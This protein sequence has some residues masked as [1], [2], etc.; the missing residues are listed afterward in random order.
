VPRRLLALL[1]LLGAAAVAAVAAAP[2]AGAHAALVGADPPA[3]ARLAAV[4]DRVTLTFSEDVA[5]SPGYLQV[6]DA[7][8][9]RVDSGPAAPVDG[10]RSRLS[11]PLR[12][13]LPPGSFLVSYAIVS[14]DSHPVS[15][16]YAFV[17]G[18]GPLLPASGGGSAGGPVLTTLLG[19]ARFVAFAGLALLGGLV[20][21]VAFWPAGRGD[22]RTRR[23]LHAGWVLGL[24]GTAGSLLLQGPAA[25]GAGSAA[26]PGLLAATL[27]TTYGRVLLLR[28]A[29]YAVLAVVCRRA[30]RPVETVGERDRTWTENTGL[31][32][33]VALVAAYGGAGHASDGLQSTDAILADMIHLAAVSVWLGGLA[34]LLAGLLPAG[35]AADAARVL[36]TW[37]R[38]AFWAVAAV[39][40]TGGYQAW[41]SL[42]GI[43][44]LWTTGYGRILAVKV[45]AVLALLAVAGVSRRAVQRRATAP[46]AGRERELV[47]VGRYAEPARP[48]APA[49]PDTRRLRRS[50]GAEVAIAAAVLALSAAL[51][52]AA[53][54]RPATG[55]PDRPQATLA[56]AAGA[57][58]TVR[59]DT[60]DR[61]AV[62]LRDAQ[63]RPLRPRQVTLTVA[64]T[65]R[66]LGPLPVA[67]TA[68]GPGDYRSAPV[69]LPHPATWT[70]R[71]RV[72]T[73]D[74][75]ATVAGADLTL[76]N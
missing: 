41:R 15:G 42:G 57:R 13:G 26:D 24:V 14:A 71:L 69:P 11:V 23:L 35:T 1:V 38:L 17:V 37:S 7:H 61:L 52:G 49:A 50:V 34:V 10:D 19:V 72:R 36:P 65:A 47:L 60:G 30:L 29:A 40:A 66:R 44:P 67:L 12:P 53:P 22:A 54:A 3:S 62:S 74:F 59:L 70:A 2:A 76:S 46:V 39:V 56:L 6:T 25:A 48:P 5:V 16:G 21:V 58:A 64:V 43:S 55:N 20:F 31:L 75:D 8:G 27:R 63:G 4:P 28:L 9:A 68:T 18:S 33:G 73:G 32:A 51:V 45:A